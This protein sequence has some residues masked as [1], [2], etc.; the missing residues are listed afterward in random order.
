MKTINL[1]KAISIINQKYLKIVIVTIVSLLFGIIYCYKTPS[2]YQ[3][4]VPIEFNNQIS[5]NLNGRNYTTPTIDLI[6]LQQA[7]E[8]M[9]TQQFVVQKLNLK[10]HY[11]CSSDQEASA[12]LNS[13]TKLITDP[14]T[15]GYVISVLDKDPQVAA[16]IIMN[17][18]NRLNLEFLT[19]R[20]CGDSIESYSYIKKLVTQLQEENFSLAQ[21]ARKKP[22]TINNFSSLQL[23]IQVQEEFLKN[24]LKLID[25]FDR[26]GTDESKIYKQLNYLEILN[27]NIQQK[28]GNL[29]EINTDDPRVKQQ[30][31]GMLLA[32]YTSILNNAYDN[33]ISSCMDVSIL[34]LPEKI[35]LPDSPLYPQKK[36]IIF[37]CLFL[38][39]SIMLALV[40]IYHRKELVE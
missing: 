26:I 11:A 10:E 8:S 40:L 5:I 14:M 6:K 32:I 19:N 37:S 12:I 30:I 23:D 36:L 29:N 39:L 22:L 24:Q 1:Y 4:T 31:N 21:E 3:V 15:M 9:A 2:Y 27:K 17:Y 20:N 25:Q 7:L 38:S 13:R 16:K 35:K 34:T 28:F 33:S 18:F